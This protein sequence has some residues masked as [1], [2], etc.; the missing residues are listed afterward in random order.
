MLSNSTG[1]ATQVP[2]AWFFTKVLRL[3][4]FSVPDTNFDEANHAPSENMK[5]SLFLDGIRTS[6]A[7]LER[8]N[9]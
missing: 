6:A 2:F 4:A 1:A 5:I 7:M 9:R 3:P 8:L